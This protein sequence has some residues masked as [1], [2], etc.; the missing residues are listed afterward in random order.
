MIYFHP[1]GY[2]I[3]SQLTAVSWELLKQ[4]H[5][6]ITFPTKIIYFIQTLL[7]A[8]QSHFIE[9]ISKD[10]FWNL[11][12]MWLISEHLSMNSVGNQNIR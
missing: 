7:E 5:G 6:Q 1:C 2:Y 12:L 4:P 8:F 9:M 11:A 10:D 3:N